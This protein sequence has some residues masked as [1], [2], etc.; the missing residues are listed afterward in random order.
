MASYSVLMAV[1]NKDNPVHFRRAAD[2]ILAQS[3]LSD[4]IVLVCDGP[5]DGEL[6]KAVEEYR[7]RFHVVQLEQNIGLGAALNEGLKH[8]RHDLVA[9]MDSDDICKP[10]RCEKQIRL[11]EKNPKLGLASCSVS[12]FT[13]KENHFVGVRTLPESH[14]EIVRYSKRRNPFN[15]PAVM[16]RKSEVEKAGG[17]TE[18]FH[19]FEDYDL[20]VRMLKNGT[21]TCNSSEPLLLMRVSDDMYKRRGGAKYANDLLRFHKMLLKTGYIHLSDFLF[22]ACPHAAVCVMP[23]GVRKAV[24]GK[25]RKE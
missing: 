15:H 1:Y 22:C 19:Y 24:Y 3:V 16:F 10:E 4:D 6:A 14:A 7:S 5:I 8:C 21:V 12:E 23:N 11:F 2:S 17:Y 20:W 9:R 18:E 13:E 25:L